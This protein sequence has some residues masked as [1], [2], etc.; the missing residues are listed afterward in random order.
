MPLAIPPGAYASLY[1]QQLQKTVSTMAI[2][3]INNPAALFAQ[4]SPSPFTSTADAMIGN[5]VRGIDTML[6]S[7]GLGITTGLTPNPLQSG[8]PFS[9]IM[10]QPGTMGGAIKPN[11]LATA[12]PGAVNRAGTGVQPNPAATSIGSIMA[13]P[14]A[15]TVG[16]ST[17]KPNPAATALPGA[18]QDISFD[19]SSMMASASNLMT[20]ANLFN[21]MPYIFPFTMG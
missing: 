5:S 2:G 17:I 12:L 8:N 21:L 10:T 7:V 6:A 19:T 13:N 15:T 14:L 11:P 1:A 9:S 4:F 20:S 16:S 3:S 18:A